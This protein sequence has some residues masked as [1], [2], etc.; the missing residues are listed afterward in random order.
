MDI[1]SKDCLALQ[2]LQ[3]NRPLEPFI[4]GFSPD[5]SLSSKE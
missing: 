3:K 1:G 5:D 4:D 2:N